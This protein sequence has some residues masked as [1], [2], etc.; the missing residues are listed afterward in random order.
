MHDDHDG[1]LQSSRALPPHLQ[2]WQLPPD[3]SWGH[4]SRVLEDRG[5]FP[6]NRLKVLRMPREVWD[7][8]NGVAVNWSCAMSGPTRLDVNYQICSR[9]IYDE[10]VPSISFDEAGICNYCH[11]IDQ[12]MK[13]HETGSAAGEAKFMA[14]VDEIKQRGRGKR[15]DC[16]IGVSGG[17]DSSYMLYLAKEWGLRPLARPLPG[18]FSLHRYH[19]RSMPSLERDGYVITELVLTASA[20]DTVARE[21]PSAEG[22]RGGVRGGRENTRGQQHGE[23]L[24]HARLLLQYQARSLSALGSL[25]QRQRRALC[26][27]PDSL[28]PTGLAGSPTASTTSGR[29]S[30]V[31]SALSKAR[32]P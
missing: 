18:L 2:T 17:T 15:Y 5:G 22:R 11:Q 23:A 28:R 26:R 12:M 20:C 32:P 31:A 4:E 1:P 10:R 25:G 9:C 29:M 27:T 19:P 7:M 3:W 24:L 8:E 6:R 21:L 30:I 14:T 16:V 13:D